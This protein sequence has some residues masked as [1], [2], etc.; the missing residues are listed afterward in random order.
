MLGAAL[1]GGHIF[2]GSIFLAPAHIIPHIGRGVGGSS[3]QALGHADIVLHVFCTNTVGI[4]GHNLWQGTP[5]CGSMGSHAGA[6]SIAHCSCISFTSHIAKSFIVNMVIGAA[7]PGVDGSGI[8]SASV[9]I[10]SG[11]VSHS[12]VWLTWCPATWCPSAESSIIFLATRVR[13]C[14][15][16]VALLVHC[17]QSRDHDI[18]WHAAMRP[19]PGCAASTSAWA[20]GVLTRRARA[21]RVQD[22]MSRVCVFSIESKL[23]ESKL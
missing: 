2:T 17:L 23:I 22:A 3:V 6:G 16:R 11:G 9:F 4:D 5:M 21:D 20:P 1:T 8:E 15:W 12:E 10:C 7:F 18:T 14:A 13:L 19:A